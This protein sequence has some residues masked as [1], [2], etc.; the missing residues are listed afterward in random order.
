MSGRAVGPPVRPFV[1]LRFPPIFL[2]VAA[3]ASILIAAAAAAPLFRSVTG[4]AAVAI[5]MRARADSALVISKPASL[6][7]DVIELRDRQVRAAVASLDDL[8]AA[9]EALNGSRVELSGDAG[10]PAAAVLATKTQFPT[11]ARLIDGEAE[12]PGLW[13]PPAAATSLGVTVGDR[14]SIW[15]G[16]RT[17]TVRVAAI[18]DA[19]ASDPYWSALFAATGDRSP[20]VYLALLDRSTFVGVE[21]ELQDTGTQTWTFPLNPQAADGLSLDRAILLADGI[22]ALDR[23]SSNPTVQ[24]GSVL[25]NPSF[26]SPVVEAVRAAEAGRRTITPSVQTLALTGQ[27]VALSGVVAAGVYGVRRRRIEMRWLDAK[28]ITWTRLWVSGGLEGALPIAVGGL[29]GWF[30]TWLAVLRLGPSSVIEPA[31]LRSS[32]AASAIS[33]VVAILVLATAT[34]VSARRQ[35][36]DAQVAVRSERSAPLWEVPTLVLAAAALYEIWTRGTEAISASDGEVQVDRLLLLFPVLFM[37]GGAG[38]LVRALERLVVRFRGSEG[39]PTW[40]YLAAR[41]VAAAPRVAMILV[42]A[43]AMAIGVLVYAGT[44]VSTIRSSTRDK[45]LV[46]T[47]A[48]V[49]ASTAG[50]I[51]PPPPGSGLRT[52]NVFEIPYVRTDVGDQ[53]TVVGVEPDSFADAAFWDGAFSSLPLESLM[54]NLAAGPSEP[55]PAIA[56]GGQTRGSPIRLNLAG[57]ELPVA[58]VASASAFPGHGQGVGIVVS[59]QSLRTVLERH[60][61]GVALQG[62]RHQTWARGD[63]DLARAFLVSKGA[64]PG[65][66]EVAADRLQTPAYRSLAW[67]FVFMELLGGV[68]AVI[69]LIGLV[70]YLQAQQRSRDLSYALGRRMG[71]SSGTHRVAIAAEIGALLVCAYV[72]GGALAFAT[73]LLIFHR[74]DPLPTLPPA[75][76]LHAPVAVLAWLALAIVACAWSAAWFVQRRAGRADVGSELRFAE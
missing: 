39:L 27:L 56:V 10:Q 29:I 71:L 16:E 45:I 50:P 13:L 28:G 59:A 6:A 74:L 49:T 22:G 24:L 38:L 54:R 70:L 63:A 20:P 43:A 60:G 15:S 65:S 21:N 47:G 42:T 46:S 34:A 11:H 23:A 57:Y 53:V 55:L 12:T 30:A 62:A 73:A 41:R 36:R 69:A 14:V 26:S 68:T 33:A 25:D 4:T 37:A 52:T 75:P 8:G 76:I 40:L 67:S 19:S 31:A 17:T 32:V 5:A 51:F 61:A 66:I 35:A 64:D 72:A 58:V 44:A 1:L 48:D 2:A 9:T 18:Y 3:A 7:Q